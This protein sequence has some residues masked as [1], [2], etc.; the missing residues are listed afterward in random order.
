MKYCRCAKCEL[1][2]VEKEG[3][4]CDI[5]AGKVFEEEDEYGGICAVCGK[6]CDKLYENC[7]CEDCKLK[8]TEDF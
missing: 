5:C 6:E 8:M 1:N 2:Y 4:I 3:D 7:I